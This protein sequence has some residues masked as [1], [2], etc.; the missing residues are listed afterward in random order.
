[1]TNI[2]LPN[3]LGALDLAA[4]DI[5]RDRERGVPRCVHCHCHG[6]TVRHALPLPQCYC[7]DQS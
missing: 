6:R 7:C 2:T 1:M 4:V 5:I 3:N